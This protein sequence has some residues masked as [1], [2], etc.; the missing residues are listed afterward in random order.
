MATD[1]HI[2]SRGASRTAPASHPFV[3]LFGVA[4]VALSVGA[5]ATVAAADSSVAA[6]IRVAPA[7]P[8]CFST[9]V[10]LRTTSQLAVRQTTSRGTYGWPLKPFN[11]QHPIRGYFND[12][13]NGKHGSHS[14]HFGIDVSAP[15]GTPV[16][17][18]LSGV[19]HMTSD[20]AVAV[21]H[22]GGW[23]TAYWHIV[24]V[25]H[26][27]QHVRKHQL[28]GRIEASWGHVHFAE[29]RG[30]EYVNPLRPGALG[31]YADTTAPTIADARFKARGRTLES[32][33]VRG[34]VDLIVDAYDTTPV[35]V[36]APWNDLPVT[37]ARLQWR[38]LKAKRV[39]VRWQTGIDF[40]YRLLPPTQFAAVYAPP[41]QK[42]YPPK[43]GRYC[44]YLAHSWDTRRLT[45][46]TYVLQ[47]NA[48][49]TQG[50]RTVGSLRFRVA[51]GR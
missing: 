5:G 21:M 30:G 26:H 13:R 11:R 1:T 39:V 25:V 15:D 31:P 19:V 10:Q 28:L 41:S 12:P 18:V 35:R 16:Y 51:N 43:V 42:N 48:T 33:R 9:P 40:R 49:D 2:Q 4:V 44:F 7:A 3:R 36:P 34:S 20:R 8:R 37:P 17:A 27:R 24:P 46:G 50:N 47:V 29:L 23:S 45:D 14:F 6:A 38:I 32:G 22:A